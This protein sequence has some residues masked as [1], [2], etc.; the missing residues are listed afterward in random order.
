LKKLIH[1]S[2]FGTDSFDYMAPMFEAEN[3]DC[4]WF[5]DGKTTCWPY[6]W[7]FTEKSFIALVKMMGFEIL[8]TAL[9]ENHALTLLAKKKSNKSGGKL[10]LD[11]QK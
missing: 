4:S 1:N 6:W 7:L 8:D 10:H 5:E 3:P 2:S 9:W 11:E